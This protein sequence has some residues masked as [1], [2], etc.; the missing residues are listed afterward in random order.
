MSVIK[1]N[2]IESTGTTAGGVEVDSSGHV[3]V[4]G[5]QMPT[6]GALSNRNLIINGAMNVAQRGTSSTTNGYGTVDRF[7]PGFTG[8]AQ[9][10]TQETLTSGSPYN[11]G[12]RKFL[13]LTNTT[14]STGTGDLRRISYLMEGQDIV[15]SGWNYT[16]SSSYITLSFWARASVSQT[17]YVEV[18]SNDG[19]AQNYTFA[20]SLTA[21]TWTKIEKT[22]PGNSSIT[23][24]NDTGAALQL[25]FIPFYGTDFTDSGFTTDVW[26]AFSGSSRAPDFTNTWAN[27]TN[28]TFDLTGVQLEVG[29]KATANSHSSYGDE[30][31]RCKRYFVRKNAPGYQRGFNGLGMGSVYTANIA[32]AYLNHDVEMRAAPTI[33]H[34]TIGD[35]QT[36]SASGNGSI[37]DITISTSTEESTILNIASSSAFH[38]ERMFILW[39][40]TNGAYIDLNAEL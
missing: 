38:T 18:I 28:A 22:I 29:E 5:V 6:A 39:S 34:K 10:Q 16:S 12:F 7:K 15:G 8:G 37:T 1:V 17:Y 35:F 40:N 36:I 2:K 25:D 13:R 26:A 23:F 9:T 27:T 3:Q 21:N 31:A 24:D 32:F 33:D 14:A 19:T 11:E 4:D 30:L 20:V